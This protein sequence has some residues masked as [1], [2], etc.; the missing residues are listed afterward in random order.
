MDGILTIRDYE[1]FFDE[2]CSVFPFSK[3]SGDEWPASLGKREACIFVFVRAQFPTIFN[4][5]LYNFMTT[6]V[7]PRYL[8]NLRN[9]FL[10]HASPNRL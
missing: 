7:K 1:Q 3:L 8:C 9:I 10:L 4:H 2:V 5:F 6:T